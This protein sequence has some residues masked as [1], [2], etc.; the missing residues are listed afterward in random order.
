M[1]TEDSH[2]TSAPAAPAVVPRG[3]GKPHPGARA[4]TPA[5]RQAVAHGDPF[6]HRERGCYRRRSDG[7]DL[8]AALLLAEGKADEMT[9]LTAGGAYVGRQLGLDPDTHPWP[10]A[11]HDLCQLGWLA[12]EGGCA[13]PQALRVMLTGQD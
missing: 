12:D 10:R 1:P 11:L 8:L 5:A 13:S 2:T 4:F 6:D 7:R 9:G 3:A